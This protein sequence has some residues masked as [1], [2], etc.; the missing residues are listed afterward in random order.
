ML[1][2]PDFEKTLFS[3]TLFFR[4]KNMLLNYYEKKSHDP[5][6]WFLEI[7]LIYD[8]GFEKSFLSKMLEKSCPTTL[9]LRKKILYKPLF[10]EKNLRFTTIVLWKNIM[11][12][13]VGFE[14]NLILCNH[15]FDKTLI[16][17]SLVFRKTLYIPDIEKN[18]VL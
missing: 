4:K 14:K 13:N 2:K 7:F 17:T 11:L 15:V 5:Q 1:N 10:W 9:V 18:I 16:S 6:S 8:A 3:T 12:Y